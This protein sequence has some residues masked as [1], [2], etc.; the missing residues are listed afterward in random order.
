MSDLTRD[1]DTE[2]AWLDWRAGGITATDVADAACGTYG[3]AHGVVARK[4]GL[5]DT[6]T[7]AAMERGHRWQPV[8]ADAMHVL[9]GLFV[10]GEESW[11]EHPHRPRHRATVDGM[12]AEAAQVT[13]DDV[14]G[15]LEIKTRGVGVRPNRDRWVAQVQWQLWVT[16]LN[17]AL[18]A[19]ATIDDDRDECVGV[20][21][22]EIAADADHQAEL[23]EVADRLWAWVEMAALPDPDGPDALPL[24]KRLTATAD[25][26]AGTVDLTE[27]ADVVARFAEIRDAERAVKAERDTLEARLRAA[28]GDATRG[29]CDGFTVSVSKPALVITDEAEAELLAARPDL[30]R[31]VLDRDRAKAEAPELVDLARRPV[32]ARRL[33]VKAQQEGTR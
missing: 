27:L 12:L 16:G 14:I 30:G 20:R 15:V 5:V 17:W 4:L 2:A 22:H 23:V 7:N 28:L 1:A 9:T 10:V 8:I 26:S 24:V 31:L 21:I 18:I 33:T 6:P 25:P 3:G 19:E 32:G 13:V 29:A 11:C